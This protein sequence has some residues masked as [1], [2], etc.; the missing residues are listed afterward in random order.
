M[1]SNAATPVTPIQPLSQSNP[2]VDPNTGK[3]SDYMM[4]Y[5]HNHSG[6]ISDN[7][8]QITV[9]TTDIDTLN[10][11]VAVLDAA[12]V[13]SASGDIVVAPA[14]GLIIDSPVLSLANTAVTAG[15][16]TSANITV[17]AKGRITAAANG[18]GGGGGGGYSMISQHTVTTAVQTVTISSIPSTFK[19]LVLVVAGLGTSGAE[20][21]LSFNGDTGSNYDYYKQNNYGG[22]GGN[23][24]YPMTVADIVT[25][26]SA[27][28]TIINYTSTLMT[29]FIL[30][31]YT[32]ELG[33]LG[34]G[35]AYGNWHPATAAA[36]ASI[37]CDASSGQ[38]YNTGSIF[39]LYG[40][41]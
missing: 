3:A 27:E 22:G 37:T 35:R 2:I 36:I 30:S 40:R 23:N 5:I 41:M 15:S 9:L 8:D 10:Q 6:Q 13:T 24:T 33:G 21:N 7:V 18:S 12:T 38:T 39:T 4:R 29:K 19:D 1:V 34:Y 11:E 20:L 31:D 25:T 14:S 26:G 32:F 17:D 16:Y 28:V